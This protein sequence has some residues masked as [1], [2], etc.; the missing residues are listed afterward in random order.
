MKKIY[1]G[2]LA[3]SLLT[4]NVS[5]QKM[6]ENFIPSANAELGHTEATQNNFTTKVLG[7]TIWTDDFS[8]GANW[9]FD[10][11]VNT[12]Y[13][14]TNYGWNIGTNVESWWAA[15]ATGINSTSGGGFAEVNNGDYFASTVDSTNNVVYTMTSSVLDIPNLPLNT[16]GSVDVSL[17]FEQFGAL[18]NDGQTVQVSTDGGTVWNEVFTNN[19]RPTFLGNNPDA[20]YANPDKI[21]VNLTPY[22]AADPSNVLIRFEWTSRF[23]G[24][25]ARGAW[26]TFGWFIDDVALVTKPDDDVQILNS[27]VV[28]TNNEGI[29]YGRTPVSQLDTDWVIGS[30]VLNFGSNDQPNTN[31]TVDF[32]SFSSS[33][34]NSIDSDSTR[35]VESTETPTLAIGV[36]TGNYVLEGA[37]DT[38]G[39]VADSDNTD[40]RTFEITENVYSMDGIGVYPT[41]SLTSLGSDSFTGAEDGLII[42]TMYH[43]KSDLVVQNLRVML[44]TGTVAGAE[45]FGSII[46]TAVLQNNGTTAIFAADPVTVAAADITAGFIDIPFAGTITLTPGAY[47]AAV[48]LTSNGGANHVRVMDDETVAQPFVGTM[49]YIPG[50]QSYTNGTA[51]GIRLVGTALGIN[52]NT[53]EGVSVY[54]NPSKGMITITNDNNASN[55]IEIYNVLGGLVYSTDANSSTSVDLSENGFGIYLVKVSNENG[56]TVKR[57]VIK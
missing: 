50:D 6:M 32:G 34:T 48:E 4:S 1:L 5:A 19:D 15:F 16:T 14:G 43:I 27:Y 11:T 39:G 23:P 22:I 44:A 47:Y 38:I 30:T 29:E 9:T 40:S 17:E 56:S 36:Y 55:A 13:T 42:G 41:T 8:T 21:A 51:A 45:I 35:Q 3:L 52:E 20:V 2:A 46:D 10:N 18:F 33:S 26:T 28:G 57:V 31:L 24:E 25:T 49:I 37:T 7:E 54:P 12:G 53:L